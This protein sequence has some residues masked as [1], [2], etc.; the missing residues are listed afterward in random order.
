MSVG[1]VRK[2]LFLTASFES[3]M[4]LSGMSVSSCS[5]WLSILLHQVIF[6]AHSRLSSSVASYRKPSWISLD[7]TSPPPLTSLWLRHTALGTQTGCD[8]PDRSSGA[9]VPASYYFV[10]HG[11]E[12]A[13]GTQP[14]VRAL[15]GEVACVSSFPVHSSIPLF[16]LSSISLFL[17]LRLVF[18]SFQNI[19]LFCLQS[20]ARPPE[21]SGHIW[22]STR[23]MQRRD[24]TTRMF[25]LRKAP[26]TSFLCPHIF[27]G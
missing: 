20:V 1:L 26:C 5:I 27:F 7:L 24:S 3:A 15:F 14:E 19:S 8:F 25:S 11:A 17:L 23:K 13:P 21:K 18:G 10:G 2:T 9:G 12:P 16:Q 22:R 4:S 6:R